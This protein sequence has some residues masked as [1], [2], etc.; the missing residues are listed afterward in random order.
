MT[1][2]DAHDITQHNKATGSSTR[3]G[4]TS[5]SIGPSS[6][7]DPH[8]PSPAMLRH[9]Q[10]QHRQNLQ[11]LH[12]PGELYA[13]Q[14]VLPPSLLLRRG[15]MWGHTHITPSPI[16]SR[17]TS[18]LSFLCPYTNQHTDSANSI[19]TTTGNHSLIPSFPVYFQTREM[20]PTWFERIHTCIP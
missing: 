20:T 15:V 19:L 11:R 12:T 13:S 14:L 2:D 6:T 17:F 1:P 10:P 16:Q 4:T 7:M 9:N 8:Q 18:Q 5:L 3:C